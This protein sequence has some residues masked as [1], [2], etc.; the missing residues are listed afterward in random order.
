[1]LD[2]GCGSGRHVLFFAQE[3]YRSHGCD[4][5]ANGIRVS[6]SRVKEKGLSANFAIAKRMRLN[7][8][9]TASMGFFA[10]GSCTICPLIGIG[11][12]FPKSTGF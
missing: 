4:F 10:S 5:S 11:E 1:M 12:Q 2:L 8:P 6:E 3:G 7:T 9:T